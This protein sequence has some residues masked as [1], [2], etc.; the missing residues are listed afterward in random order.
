MALDKVR[1]VVWLKFGFLDVKKRMKRYLSVEDFVKTR[2]PVNSGKVTALLIVPIY[3]ILSA[4][5]LMFYRL[6]RSPAL[7]RPRV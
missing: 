1:T 7:R 6:F 3:I 2:R 4:H 5:S